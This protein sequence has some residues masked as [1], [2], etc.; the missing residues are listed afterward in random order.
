MLI[1]SNNSNTSNHKIVL[2]FYL[3]A[4][5]A[6]LI[7]CILLLFSADSFNQNHFSPKLLALTH[8]MALG[9][10]T[11]IIMGA[12]HQLIP[13]LIEN[14]L[15]SNKLALTSFYFLAIGI[16]LLVYG[17][18]TFNMGDISKWGGRLIILSVLSYVI[19][20][21]ISIIKSK[22]ENVHILFVFVA[23]IWLLITAV[24]GLAL[25][26]NFSTN[27]LPNDSLMYLPMHA[28]AG[29]VGWFLLIIIGV[30]SRLIPMFLISKYQ[31]T[32][33]LKI[34][35]I[36]INA[37]MLTYV[38]TFNN[39]LN[40]YSIISI[41]AIITSIILFINYCRIAY[42]SRIK[43]KLDNQIKIS[44]LSVMIMTVPIIILIL[45]L[46]LNYLND[47]SN[48]NLVLSYG[49]IIFFG[50][51]TAIILGMTFKT[52]PFIIWNKIYKVQSSSNKFP[53]P[54]E[55]YSQQIFKLMSTIYVLSII[56]FSIG[57]IYN[58]IWMLQMGAVSF[59]IVATLY[60]INVIKLI[61]NHPK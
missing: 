32:K 40:I 43:K 55:L 30:G 50:W 17:F 34:I 42:K 57:I 28:H 9:W 47:K 54:N 8:T 29:I 39:K 61:L 46:T 33:I 41:V 20:I 16:P 2:P 36:L 60:N 26:Y 19:N 23:S 35:L 10:G 52:L 37:A 58:L 27:L 49:F 53:N 48:N 18:L 15:Y 51:M 38:L 45:I 12:S 11:M 22:S 21:A 7:A 1:N 13:V 3:Y 59:I 4:A 6:F 14:K 24:F 44:L 56:I 31:S 25:I 5:I